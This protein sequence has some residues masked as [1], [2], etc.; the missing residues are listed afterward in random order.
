MRRWS[1]GRRIGRRERKERRRWVRR[2]REVGKGVG[3]RGRSIGG[4]GATVC[5]HGVGD[6]KKLGEGND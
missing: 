3:K 2:G 5:L 1:R 6:G 4:G